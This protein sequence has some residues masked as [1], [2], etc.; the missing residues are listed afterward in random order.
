MRFLTSDFVAAILAATQ[1]G[2]SRMLSGWTL[3]AGTIDFPE[4]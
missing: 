4:S 3:D 1:D 2:E